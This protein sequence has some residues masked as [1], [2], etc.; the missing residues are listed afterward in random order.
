MGCTGSFE[1][2]DE[3]NKLVNYP[4]ELR[5]FRDSR[6]TEA[7]LHSMCFYFKNPYFC[8]NYQSILF[9]MRLISSQPGYLEYIG[10]RNRIRLKIIVRS[11]IDRNYVVSMCVGKNASHV[12]SLYISLPK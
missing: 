3:M 10:K 6:G 1:I 12:T 7:T 2:S 8:Y 9:S 5:M 11:I 4:S